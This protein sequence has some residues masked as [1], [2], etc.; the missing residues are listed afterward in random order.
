M[1]KTWRDYGAM[2]RDYT[3]DEIEFMKTCNQSKRDKGR[4]LSDA[5]VLEIAFALGYRKVAEPTQLPGVGRKAR[6]SS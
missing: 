6:D 3:P 5:E 2:A 4:N 1:R